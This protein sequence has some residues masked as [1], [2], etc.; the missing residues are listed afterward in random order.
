MD[1]CP[2]CTR[3]PWGN[4]LHNRLGHFTYSVTS[5][6]P[7]TQRSSV[8]TEPLRKNLLRAFV[9]PQLT[10]GR[11]SR[12]AVSQSEKAVTCKRSQVL[13]YNGQG[14]PRGPTLSGGFTDAPGVHKA[15]ETLAHLP[16]N[17]SNLWSILKKEN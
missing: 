16:R 10:L 12:S 1:G 6:A 4:H 14:P 9:P 3:R 2:L 17:Y 11:Q 8:N 13:C 7:G 15:Q 5:T